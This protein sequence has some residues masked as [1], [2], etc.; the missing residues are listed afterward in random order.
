MK[1]G[2]IYYI[3]KAYQT[4]GSEQQSG[5]PAIIVSNDMCNAHSDVVEV[6]YLTTQPKTDLPTHI[7]I[8][9][10]PKRSIAL[11]EQISSVSV[12]R[13]GEFVAEC[14][15]YEMQMIDAALEISLGL[16]GSFVKTEK[17]MQEQ[18]QSVPTA[19]K[20]KIED[21]NQEILRAQ[22]ERDIYK[23]LYTEML[24]RMVTAR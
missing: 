20:S 23:H 10:S 12:S 15:E 6:V 5:R 16:N 13:I 22:T 24:E 7:D 4:V 18:K 11:C 14:S 8:R 1:R 21:L 9:S 17:V 3:E 19:E 2:E